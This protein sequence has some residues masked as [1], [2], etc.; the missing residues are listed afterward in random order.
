MKIQYRILNEDTWNF[1]KTGCQ[2]GVIATAKV[3]TGTDRASR[4]RIVQPG[5]REWVIIIETI[6]ARGDAI[7][8]LVIFKVVM[9]QAA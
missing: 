8:P 6:N 1:N 9:H 4:P 2:M 3:I 7:P 5:N